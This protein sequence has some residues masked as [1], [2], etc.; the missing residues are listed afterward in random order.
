MK[1]NTTKTRGLS[2]I[3]LKF[4]CHSCTLP[5]L[6]LLSQSSSGLDPRLRDARSLDL[7]F[8]FGIDLEPSVGSAASAALLRTGSG[9]GRFEPAARVEGLDWALAFR[10]DFALPRLLLAPL[11]LA[12]PPLLLL[13][14]LLLSSW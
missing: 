12:P 11:L 2:E 6:V 9:R 3:F 7:V 5:L 8:D 1:Q 13:L 4:W 10:C 14:L